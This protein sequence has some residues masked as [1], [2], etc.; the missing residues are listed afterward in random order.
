[1]LKKIFHSLLSKNRKTN[2][3]IVQSNVWFDLQNLLNFYGVL[4][5]TFILVFVLYQ[6]KTL[7]RGS[8]Y[9]KKFVN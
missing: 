6:D 9:G 2:E 4:S 7:L 5:L 1:M 8:V 3:Q